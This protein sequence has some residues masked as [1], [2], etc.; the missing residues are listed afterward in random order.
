MPD[1]VCQEQVSVIVRTPSIREVEVKLQDHSLRFI[2]LDSTIENTLSERVTQLLE[3]Y[4]ASFEN[5][6]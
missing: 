5:S 6:R 1:F 3:S 4:T 2:S